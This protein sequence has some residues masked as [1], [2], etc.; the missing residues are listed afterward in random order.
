MSKKGSGKDRVISKELLPPGEDSCNHKLSTRDGYCQSPGVT[1]FNRCGPHGGVVGMKSAELFTK[2]VGV[3]QAAKLQTLLEDTLCMDNELA[4]G[5]TILLNSLEQYQRA[6]YVLEKYLENP[7]ERPLGDAEPGEVDS[8][9]YAVQMHENLMAEAQ[10]LKNDSF[11]DSLNMIRTLTAG[12]QRNSKIREGSKV[13]MDVKQ[14]A[15]IIRVQL[16]VMAEHCRGCPK[17]KAV[18]EGMQAG[19][20][21]IPI[22]MNP[23]PSTKKAMG[24]RA[25]SDLVDSVTEHMPDDAEFSEE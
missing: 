1:A 22:N 9:A 5:K 13:Q 16:T 11:K 14:V 6:S 17:L 25:Y 10:K 24:L 19:T 18:I 8:Y 12:I 2:A 23:S 15:A 20:K 3:E 21:D 7:P 4:S